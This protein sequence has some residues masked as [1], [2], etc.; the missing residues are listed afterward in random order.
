MKALKVAVVFYAVL[1]AVAGLLIRYAIVSN[2]ET[3][4][5]EAIVNEVKDLIDDS[6]RAGDRIAVYGRALV[7]DMQSNS[8][9]DVNAQL[10]SSLQAKSTDRP[11]TVFMVIG[12]RN[13][14]VGT[15]SIS[16]E[17]AYR[18]YVDI[19][20]ASWP[21]KKALGFHSVVSNEPRSSRQVQ[22][23]PEYGGINQP[24]ADWINTLPTV[25]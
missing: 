1:F 8:R 20:V 15:Y 9:S 6:R 14:Q 7:W 25:Q 10:Q 11:I 22:S 21:E 18:Q 3:V 5:Q 17:P 13:E 4:A 23:T 2:R 24:V 12:T 16:K 19:A